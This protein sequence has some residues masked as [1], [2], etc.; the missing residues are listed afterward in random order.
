MHIAGNAFTIH[1]ILAVILFPGSFTYICYLTVFIDV[2]NQCKPSFSCCLA[3]SF[4]IKPSVQAFLVCDSVIAE[5][6]TGKKTI[7]GTFVKLHAAAFP[8]VLR[9]IGLYFCITDAS[10]EYQFEFDLV[11]LDQLTIVTTASIPEIVK[12]DDRLQ[13]NDYAVTVLDVV[14]PKAGK[15][16]FQLKANKHVIAIKELVAVP[17]EI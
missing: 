8:C 10:G 16:Q 2:G 4:F 13:I 5:A 15:Y 9:S 1:I 11:D 7:V 3:I 6:G 12:I 17:F 14:I